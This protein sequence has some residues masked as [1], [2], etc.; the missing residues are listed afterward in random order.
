MASSIHPLVP[1]PL[2][3]IT[4]SL[5]F[6]PLY[7]YMDSI[8]YWTR[9]SLVYASAIISYYCSSYTLGWSHVGVSLVSQDT[10]L[11]LFGQMS[12][13]SLSCLEGYMSIITPI[14]RFQR[15]VSLVGALDPQ[16]VQQQ[17]LEQEKGTTLSR[18]SLGGQSPAT[19]QAGNEM[20]S[21]KDGR[22]HTHQ[23]NGF[24]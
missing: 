18:T 5:Y 6:P 20:A 8:F 21:C 12:F 2:V 19:L 14:P 10:F 22:H 23:L 15:L 13:M 4:C 16:K 24:Q 11:T 1:L 17:K 9:P 3:R 7:I